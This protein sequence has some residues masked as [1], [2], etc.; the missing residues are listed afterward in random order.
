MV[1]EFRKFVEKYKLI[2]EGDRLL[3][4]M[5]G[6][7]DS[8]VLAELLLKSGAYI[9]VAHCNFQLRGDDSDADE[10]FVMDWC[11]KNEVICHIRKFQL[12]T[13]DSGKS[14]QEEAR[15]VRYNW[16]HELLVHRNLNKLVTAHHAS[17]NVETLF[18]NLL[19]GSG[20]KGW[21]GIPLKSAQIIRPLLFT[22]KKHIEAFARQQNISFR[23]DASNETDYY[24]RNK[25]RHHLIPGL[26]AMNTD[27]ERRVST[28]QIHLQRMVE[29]M[30]TLIQQQN[31]DII[32]HENKQV[33]IRHRDIQPAGFAAEILFLWLQPF[34]FNAAQS[35]EILSTEQSGAQFFSASHQLLINRNEILI[36]PLGKSGQV[37]NTVEIFRGQQNLD[38]PVKLE[39]SEIA[40]GSESISRS[41]QVAMLD[42]EVLE[43]PLILRRWQKGD[44]FQPLGM[45]KQKLVS[46]FLIDEKVN[47]FDKENQWVLVSGDQIIWVLGR[48]I[49]ERSKVTTKTSFVFKIRM[50]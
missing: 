50:I 48:R 3:L 27:F 31:Q 9:E 14:V 20:A 44:K 21:S 5:S 2:A 6:G 42:L 22:S 46:D 18:I 40:A 11:L 47:R 28:N 24:L 39:F 49:S 19:R 30:E 36:K 13:A 23:S 33:I 45:Q 38:S 43:F 17:D 34:G 10:T 12:K 35:L 4:A 8:M 7:V 29:L 16:F 32:R 26:A 37:E 15:V 1:S 25:I 41:P